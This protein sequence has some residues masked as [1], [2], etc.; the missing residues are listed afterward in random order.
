MN[1]D[2][3]SSNGTP[4]IAYK[5]YIRKADLSYELANDVCNGNNAVIVANTL[6]IVSLGQLTSAPY[7]LLKGYSVN[8]KV[9]ATNAYGDSLISEAGNGAI[10]VVVPD[11][12]TLLLNDPL[13]T[14]RTQIGL[15]WSDGPSNGGEI[16]LDYRITYD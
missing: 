12:P 13:I 15:K 3:P 10:I 7:S 16:V 1:W 5:V 6:C 4:I 11:A 14:S 8:I 2:A 9:I